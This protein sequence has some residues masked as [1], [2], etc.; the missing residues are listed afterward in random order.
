[1]NL[2]FLIF[3]FLLAFPVSGYK[4][5]RYVFSGLDRVVLRS[6]TLPA[7]NISYVISR[8]NMVYDALYGVILIGVVCRTG[9]HRVCVLEDRI[10]ACRVRLRF[11]IT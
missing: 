6:R 10:V 2:P 4:V 8:A 1:M 5:G 11:D 7:D 3:D 9:S